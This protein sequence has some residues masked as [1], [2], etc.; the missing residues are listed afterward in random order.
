M[1]DMD[2]SQQQAFDSVEREVD[3]GI[4]MFQCLVALKDSAIDQQALC[5][6]QT[7]DGTNRSHLRGRRDESVSWSRSPEWAGA[8]GRAG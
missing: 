8:A 4:R 5:C 2:V 7:V 3:F 6:P 1:I